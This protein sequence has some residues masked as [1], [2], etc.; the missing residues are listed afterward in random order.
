MV[1]PKHFQKFI[2]PA[3]GKTDISHKSLVLNT[4][5]R[6][7]VP[8]CTLGWLLMREIAE[9]VVGRK[10]SVFYGTAIAFPDGLHVNLTEREE[11]WM[12]P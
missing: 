10:G 8:T 2:P 6:H 9:E 7:R 4:S 5:K 12:S 1:R 11:S 3:V